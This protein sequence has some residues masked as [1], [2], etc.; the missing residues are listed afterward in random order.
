MREKKESYKMIDTHIHLDKY[1]RD[2]LDKLIEEWRVGGVEGVVAV[3]TDL[4]SAYDTLKLKEMYPEFIYVAL[5]YHPEQA[6]PQGQELNELRSL[7][8]AERNRIVAIG[9]IGLPHYELQ[10]LGN[11]P[12]EVYLELLQ[13]FCELAVEQE[14]PL[15][16]HAVHDKAELALNLL[17][18]NNVVKAHFHWLKAPDHIAKKIVHAGYY[19]SVTPEVCYRE[20]DQKLVEQVPLQQLLLETDGPWQYSK[21]FST[22]K[23]TPLFL[24]EV[25]AKVGEIKKVPPKDV[26][27]VCT[28]NS[29]SCFGIV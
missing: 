5:G 4:A 23:T 16:L 3:S 17:A 25:V 13:N 14:L 22:R 1:P 15:V 12:L 9:E 11:P 7:I 29:L 28:L 10:A 6:L 24:H 27:E 20:R 21:S 19:I 18:Q 2:H 8:K 26:K